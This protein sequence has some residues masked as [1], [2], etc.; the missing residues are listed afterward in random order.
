MRHSFIIWRPYPHV[1]SSCLHQECQACLVCLECQCHPWEPWVPCL[2][3]RWQA[4]SSKKAG[5]DRGWFPPNSCLQRGFLIRLLADISGWKSEET[6]WYIMTMSLPCLF[7]IF[8]SLLPGFGGMFPGNRGVC[9]SVPCLCCS[10]SCLPWKR[11][12]WKPH[13]VEFHSDSLR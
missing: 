13:I 12:F 11:S 6:F 7:D 8:G 2:V 4:G 1:L 3:C 10:C 5:C 9:Y